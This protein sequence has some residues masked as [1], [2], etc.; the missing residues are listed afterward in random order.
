MK[1]SAPDDVDSREHPANQVR[2]NLMAKFNEALCVDLEA[3]QTPEWAI[4]R[5]LDVEILTSA[6]IDPCVGL[7][8]IAD[9]AKKRGYGVTS[10]DVYHWGYD[11]TLIQD[12]LTTT[13][14]LTNFTVL[15]NL[16]FSKACA[17][18]DHALKLNARKVVCFQRQAWRETGNGKRGRRAWWDAN[19]PAR[20]WLCGDRASCWR[21]D[22]LTCPHDAECPNRRR[23]KGQK[24]SPGIGCSKCMG[25]T[26]TPHEFYV[27]ERGHVAAEISGVLYK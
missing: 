20:K 19:K 26:P 10:Y 11:G 9:A 5:L 17:F 27:W 24:P 7:G 3:Y 16:P 2:G 1:W 22:V 14:D 21:F 25:N 6:V 12:W 15:M 18:V 13:I 4:E 8:V 23:K